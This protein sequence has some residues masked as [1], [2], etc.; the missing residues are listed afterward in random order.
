[1][2][3]CLHEDIVLVTHHCGTCDTFCS[4]TTPAK[5]DR[6]VEDVTSDMPWTTMCTNTVALFCICSIM[7]QPILALEILVVLRSILRLLVGSCVSRKH[8]RHW[9]NLWKE[10]IF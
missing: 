8:K 5:F 4:S 9:Q 6:H 3:A 10:M 2:Q 7:K 1:M